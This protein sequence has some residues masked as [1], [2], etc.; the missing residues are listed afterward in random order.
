MEALADFG[1]FGIPID[2]ESVGF[3]STVV[4]TWERLRD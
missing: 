3:L 1:L 2:D 4:E